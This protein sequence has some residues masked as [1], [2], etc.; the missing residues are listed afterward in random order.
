MK[1]TFSQSQFLNGTYRLDGHTVYKGAEVVGILKPGVVFGEQVNVNQYAILGPSGPFSVAH[2]DPDSFWAGIAK[3]NSI[4][5]GT[6]S[7]VQNVVE[8]LSHPITSRNFSYLTLLARDCK[9]LID[10]DKVISEATI[11]YIGCGGVGSIS[12]LTLAGMNVRKIRL[13]DHDIIEASNLNRQLFFTQKDIGKYKVD[14]LKQRIHERFPHVEVETHIDDCSS[15]QKMETYMDD[16][17]VVLLTADDPI[18]ISHNAI[19]IANKKQIQLI[20]T[21][22][23]VNQ[24]K[25]N[26]LTGYAGKPKIRWSRGPNFIAPS[27]GPSNV[28]LAGVASSTIL[29]ALLN[30]LDPDNLPYSRVWSN[31]TFN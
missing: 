2:N 6:S 17:D 5:F 3:S 11:S 15:Y 25:V 20:S 18:T 13:V 27:Y 14:V 28:E 7:E 26:Y 22:Y 31:M 12:S 9:E 29:L 8:L 4:L 21:G 10:F 30:Q 24:L 19:D 23:M 1:N 16:S